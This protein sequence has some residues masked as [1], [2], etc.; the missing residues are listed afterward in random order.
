LKVCFAVRHFGTF[1]VQVSGTERALSKLG[2]QLTTRKELRQAR[3]AL[4][5]FAA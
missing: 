4:I 3:N 2:L 5:P 1:T